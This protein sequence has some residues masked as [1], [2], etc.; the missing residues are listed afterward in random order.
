MDFCDISKAFDK[1]RHRYGIG[2]PCLNFDKTVLKVI[3]YVGLQITCHQ[4]SKKLILILHHLHSTNYSSCCVPQG[5]VWD[6]FYTLY[7]LMT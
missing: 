4:E 1:V 7:M 2:D 3:F 5:S 6:R